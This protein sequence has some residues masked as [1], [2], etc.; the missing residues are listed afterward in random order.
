MVALA[1]WSPVNRFNG[2]ECPCG[3]DGEDRKLVIDGFMD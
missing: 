3:I 2:T 1:F